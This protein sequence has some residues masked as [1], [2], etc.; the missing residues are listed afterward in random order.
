[1]LH[2]LTRII[3][4]PF[5][6]RTIEAKNNVMKKLS[7]ILFSLMLFFPMAYATTYYVDGAKGSDSFTGTSWDKAFK[8]IS[9]ANSTAGAGDDV[10][11]KAGTYSFIGSFTF[12]SQN[13]YGGFAGTESSPSERALTDVDGNGIIE[14]WEFQNT[15]TLS[16]TYSGGTA[17]LLPS[18]VVTVNGFTF[19]HTGTR[20]AGGTLRTVLCQSSGNIFENNCIKNCALSTSMSASIGGMLLTTVGTIRNCL[21]ENNQTTCSSTGDFGV[22]LGVEVLANTKMNGCVFRNNRATADFSAVT[23]TNA[24]IRGFVI[25]VAGGI[26]TDATTHT[27]VKNCLFYNN[28]TNYIGNATLTTSSNGAIAALTAFSSSATTDSIINCTFA[29]NKATNLKTAG[30][31][32]IKAGTAIHWVYNN[33]FWNNQLGGTVKNIQTAS[34]SSLTSGFIGNNVMNGGGVS[35]TGGIASNSYC[36]NNKTDL[37][38]SNTGTN[39]PGFINPTTVIGNTN[40]GTVEKAVWCIS[41]GSYL[42]G[43]GV[44]TTVT[45][46]KADVAFATTPTTGAYEYV[47]FKSNANGNWNSG[48][49]W[50][51]SYDNSNWIATLSNPSRTYAASVAISN[52]NLV[53]IADNATAPALT[54]NGGGKLTL[55]NG[56]TLNATSL[57]IGSDVTN[58]TG[59]FID[60][61]ANGGLMVSGITTVKQYLTSGRNWY[62]S[63]PLTA[64]SSAV[65]SATATN[66]LY[67]YVEPNGSNINTR[68]AQI[69]A[70][71]TNLTPTH[72]YI[73]NMDGAV[74][75]SQS[76][77]ITF[78]G[79]T[80]NTGTITTDAN[81]TPTLTRTVGIA[82]E[83]FNL[84]GNPYPSF[85]DIT[86]LQSNPDLEASYWVRS[87]NNGYVFDTYNIPGDMGTGLS[88]KMV[89]SKIAP[90]Q[91][92]WVRV[93][94][95]SSTA[96]VS[97]TNAMRAHQDDAGNTFRVKS[98][99][100]TTQPV[101]RLQVSNGTNFDETVLYFNSN[102]SNNYDS[103]DSPKMMNNSATVP[104]L[105]T[106]VGNENLVINGMNAIPYDT[107]IPLGFAPGSGTQF[108]IKATE[109]TN[110]ASGTQIL[111]KDNGTG[112]VTDLTSTDTYTFDNS[113]SPTGRFSLLFKVPGTTTGINAPNN[114]GNNSNRILIYRNANNQITVNCNE[115]DN[116]AKINVYNA[117]GQKLTEPLLTKS[118]T[119]LDN[120]FPSGV[121]LVSVSVDGK[122][123]VKKVILN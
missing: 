107:E 92:F 85:V 76:N 16:S 82:K 114:D 9:T 31:N 11:V 108:S 116:N 1:M 18:A 83:G 110:F 47:Y 118:L 4:N 14:P 26:T 54:I 8:N 84:I 91:A 88:G 117:L 20:T 12:G 86:S 39:P 35:G 58:G 103:Y 80:L 30:L 93:K 73:I 29:N 94:S 51:T 115:A 59:T 98:S 101:L 61:N 27:T 112:A 46:D 5:D 17:F 69:T 53:T 66:P 102:A 104:D 22:M 15:T 68:W 65:F 64:A 60:L 23:T 119:T 41:N 78:T 52:G 81:S 90:M 75:T 77:L 74:M 43:K 24:N 10:Y 38:T 71:D 44:A 111:L 106:V 42:Y 45:T 99:T 67:Y 13:W 37:N 36:A 62:I 57:T 28:E 55:N 96:T 50:Q 34:A 63:S 113:V 95:G 2:L 79:G 48:A 6:D 122:A 21:F 87:Y 25:N 120:P 56:H 121:Y 32:I 97:F 100:V 105:Y 70:S 7:T 33:A 19:T 40:D 109:L 123:T 72:G 49:T 3:I 89:S